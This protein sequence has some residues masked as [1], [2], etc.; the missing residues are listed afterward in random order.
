MYYNIKA[1][2]HQDNYKDFINIDIRVHTTTITI[3]REKIS[4]ESLSGKNISQLMNVKNP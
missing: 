2:S 1:H 3:T 4:L